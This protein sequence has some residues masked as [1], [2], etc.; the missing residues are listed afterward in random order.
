[1]SER[2]LAEESKSVRAGHCGSEPRF[3]PFVTVRLSFWEILIFLF[4]YTHKNDGLKVFIKGEIGQ[5]KKG[6]RLSY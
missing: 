2:D 6:G 5:R 1:M 4:N 3:F